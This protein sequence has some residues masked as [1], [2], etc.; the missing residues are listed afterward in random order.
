MLDGEGT[1]YLHIVGHPSKPYS[2]FRAAC[3]EASA[4]VHRYGESKYKGSSEHLL[5]SGDELR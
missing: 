4:W 5:L 3:T 1:Y 2:T